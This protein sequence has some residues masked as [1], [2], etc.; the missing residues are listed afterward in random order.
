MS[1]RYVL[2][3]EVDEHGECFVTLPDEMLEETGWDVGTE[4]EWLE[5]TDGSIIL[6][7][8]LE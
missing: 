7:E 2:E 4:L 8:I 1:K 6:K 3:V 5:E